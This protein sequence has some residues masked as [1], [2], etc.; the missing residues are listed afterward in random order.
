MIRKRIGRKKGVRRV[1]DKKK[2]KWKR[3]KGAES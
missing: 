1:N 2:G 3:E